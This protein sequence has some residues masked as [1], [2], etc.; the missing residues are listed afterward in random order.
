MLLDSVQLSSV[1][2]VAPLLLASCPISSTPPLHF[3]STF[4]KIGLLFLKHQWQDFSPPHPPQGLLNKRERCTIS[5]AYTTIYEST[6]TEIVCES[7]QPQEITVF[8]VYGASLP[9]CISLQTY[10]Q[11]FSGK[12]KWRC[13]RRPDSAGNKKI[14]HAIHQT[15]Q[16]KRYGGGKRSIEWK[17]QGEK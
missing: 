15:E 6:V 8:G 10:F 4:D 7:L 16:F 14:N 12:K 11:P 13:Y 9:L 3:Y 5:V 1:Y 2:S 17:V